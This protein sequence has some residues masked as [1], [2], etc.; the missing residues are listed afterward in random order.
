MRNLIHRALTHVILISTRFMKTFKKMKG[1]TLIELLIVI[2]LIAVLAGAILVALNPARQF[3]QARNSERWSHVNAILSLVQQNTVENR[4]TWTCPEGV[5][6]NTTSTLIASTGYDLCSC[7]VPTYTNAL[8]FDPN[9]A[10]A[11]YESCT[12][13]N[14]GYFIYQDASTSRIT[15]NAPGAELG[16]TISVTQ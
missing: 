15:V 1:F 16:A 10:D 6:P 14:T 9:R 4:G 7:L 5:L 12:N 11:A 2:A 3:A 8:P 13:Y